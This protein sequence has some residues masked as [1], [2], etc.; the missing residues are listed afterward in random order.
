MESWVAIRES[1]TRK[2]YIAQDNM[3]YPIY[4][5]QDMKHKKTIEEICIGIGLSVIVVLV[6][7][8]SYKI[9]KYNTP[10]TAVWIDDA[11]LYGYTKPSEYHKQNPQ[12]ST[13]VKLSKREL[14]TYKGTYTLMTE[15]ETKD[16]Q[17]YDSIKNY[18]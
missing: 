14:E 15:E 11:V 12:N 1:I 7:F 18:R 10:I 16:V 17:V 2:I 4:S 9:Y 8:I 3:T 5:D 13:G 6:C